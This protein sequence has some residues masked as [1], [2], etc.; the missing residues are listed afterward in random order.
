MSVLIIV[1]CNEWDV[2]EY[3]ARRVGKLRRIQNI[4]EITHNTLFRDFDGYIMRADGQVENMSVKEIIPDKP[5][6]IHTEGTDGRKR[7]YKSAKGNIVQLDD[8]TAKKPAPWPTIDSFFRGDRDRAVELFKEYIKN[9]P[10]TELLFISLIQS[11]ARD[12]IKVK[13]SKTQ[14]GLYLNPWVYKKYKQ[15]P[16]VRTIDELYLIYQSA[17]YAETRIKRGIIDGA[18]AAEILFKFF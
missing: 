2:E 15:L 14:K 12:I 1:S 18:S 8:E 13:S 9:A 5:L 6:I 17:Q 11:T 10:G 4:M 3:A 7:L 16:D